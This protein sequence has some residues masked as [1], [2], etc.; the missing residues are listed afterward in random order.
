MSFIN[1][2][3]YTKKV[4]QWNYFQEE[5]EAEKATQKLSEEI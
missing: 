2:R 1:Y 3:F 4:M 5:L